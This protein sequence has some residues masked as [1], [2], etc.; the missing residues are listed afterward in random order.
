MLQITAASVNVVA[1]FPVMSVQQAAAAQSAA[2][3]TVATLIALQSVLD[4]SGVTIVATSA[5]TVS[6]ALSSGVRLPSN[7]LVV[8]DSSGLSW[9]AFWYAL[10]YDFFYQGTA[11]PTRRWL[12]GPLLAFLCSLWA[13]CLWAP[14]GLACLLLPYLC[15]QKRLLPHCVAKWVGRLYFRPCLPC[16]I[17]GHQKIFK[18]RWWAFVDDG[19]GGPPVIIGQ[20]MTTEC[21]RVHLIAIDCH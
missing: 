9:F 12:E 17:Y 5:A 18:G 13:L 16:T 3:S 11:R 7:T 10:V 14:L 15:F 6:I 8:A 4:S 21:T 1:T 19:D 20:V 2:L